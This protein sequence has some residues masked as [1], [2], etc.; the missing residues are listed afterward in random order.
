[1]LGLEITKRLVSAFIISRL[2]YCN[3]VLAGL[4]QSTIAPLQRVQNAAARLVCNLGPLEQITASLRELHWLPIR[5]RITFKLCLTMPNVHVGHSPGY[6]CETVKPISAMANR[7][8]LR[9][10]TGSDY[11]LPVIRRKLGERAFPHAGPVAWNGLPMEIRSITDTSI[12]KSRLK[13]YLFNIAYE[14]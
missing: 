5:Q 12:F 2:D 8:R 3:S 14:N 9:S 4:P 10:L 11:E 7:S 6:I 13:T 1:M